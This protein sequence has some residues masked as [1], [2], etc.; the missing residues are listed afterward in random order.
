M[1]NNELE[2]MRS[3]LSVL[4]GKLE[5]VTIVSDTMLSIATKKSISHMQKKLLIR[6]AIAAVLAY[7]V[8]GFLGHW[9]LYWLL[10][11]MAL[12]ISIYF[13]V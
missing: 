12:N 11:A 7:F 8:D 9:F 6:I 1:E 3:Q 5:N 4:N 13:R 10:G 2:E